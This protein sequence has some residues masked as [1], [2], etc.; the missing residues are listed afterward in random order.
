MSQS[1]VPSPAP[2]WRIE[3]NLRA[4]ATADESV[5]SGDTPSSPQDPYRWAQASDT[6][7][8][9]AKWVIGALAAVGAVMFA[10]GIVV[11]PKLSV[12]ENLGQLL[13]AGILGVLGVLGIVTLIGAASRVLLPRVVTLGDLPPAFKAKVES[14]TGRRDYLP[15]GVETIEQLRARI[16]G[17]QAA[18]A[19]NA[20]RIADLQPTARGDT[21]SEAAAKAEELRIR[22]RDQAG[23]NRDLAVLLRKRMQLLDAARFWV[24]ANEY[25]LSSKVVLAGAVL[26]AVGGI[27][28]QLALATP[29][30]SAAKATDA[31]A[32]TVSRPTFGDLVQLN[33]P[34]SRAL[35]AAVQLSKCEAAGRTPPTVRVV[36]LSGDGTSDH[37]YLVSPVSSALQCPSVSFNVIDEVAQVTL[38]VPT[39]ITYTTPSA[40]KSSPAS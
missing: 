22:Q 10:K 28:F 14:D 15:A 34:A 1:G 9:T 35:W 16:D 7:Q 12:S 25:T 39:E 32:K 11:T 4:G 19:D 21:L 38:V 23:Q 33:T 30:A 31:G 26:A 3:G 27:G 24:V 5:A 13:W 40:T 37:P 6:V 20:D 29:E 8:T 18:I 2:G 36:V 17:T